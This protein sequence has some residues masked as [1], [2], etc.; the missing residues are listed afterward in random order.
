MK[1]MDDKYF[2]QVTSQKGIDV[3]MQ[4]PLLGMEFGEE[5]CFMRGE[6]YERLQ[7]AAAS[8]PEGLS[9]RIWDAWRPFVLQEELY[10]VY[11]KQIVEEF[12][13][14]EASEEEQKTMIG[15]F[16]ALPKPDRSH[17]PTHTTGGALDVT[18]IDP[19]GNELAMGT[20]FD[21]FSPKTYT[22]Y[23]EKEDNLKIAENAEPPTNPQI[24]EMEQIRNNRRI[25]LKAMTNAGFVNLDSEWWH[26]DYGDR[27]WAAAVKEPI[28]YD[29]VFSVEEMEAFP[30]QNEEGKKPGI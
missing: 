19:C 5:R 8:L 26:Y 25:L 21:S 2:V 6:V 7:R 15:N 23:Y 3:K 20:A 29:G 17:P 13:L 4:Y 14:Q 10:R 16:V 11:S 18:L 30:S 9:I 28:I 12:G 27:L 24:E 22:D 1:R